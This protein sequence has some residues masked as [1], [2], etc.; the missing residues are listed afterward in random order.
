[1]F[2]HTFRIKRWLATAAIVA[3]A[4]FP[5]SAQAMLNNGGGGGSVS[6]TPPVVKETAPAASQTGSGFQWGDAGIGAAGAVVL[7]SAGTL[8]ASVARRRGRPAVG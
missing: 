2:H 3:G 5:A 1:M 6:S 4:G 8:G 7:L